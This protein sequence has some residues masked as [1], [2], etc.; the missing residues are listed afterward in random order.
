MI[1]RLAAATALA[2]VSVPAISAPAEGPSRLLQGSDLFS[3]EVATDPQIRPDG[4]MIAYVRRSNDVMTDR[5]RATIWLVDAKTGAQTPLVAGTG[6]HSQ[7]RWSPDGKR[8]AYVSTAEGG[9]A[10]L[11]VRWMDTGA[12]ARVATLPDGPSAISWSPDGTRIAFIMSV[13]DE[14][15]KLGTPPA[16]PEGAKWAPPLEVISSIVYRADGAG[17]LKPGYDHVFVVPADGGA[18]RQLTFGA[19][20]HDGPLSWTPDGRTILLS[21]DRSK[22]WQREPNNPE[23]YALDVATAKLTALTDRLGPDA[24]PVVSPDGKRI[25]Y[26]GYD[27]KYRG[28]ENALLYV[29]DRDGGNARAI[30]TALDRSIDDAEWA[31]DGRSLY[32]QYDDHGS[33]RV[34]RVTLDGKLTTVAT[35]MTSS[36]I[37]RPYSGGSFSVARNGAVA[38]TS[39]DPQRPADVSIASGGKSRRLTRLNE[40]LLGAKALGQ[41]RQIPVKAADGRAID[42][43]LVTP[44]DFD[45]AKKYPM[46]LEI[47][48]GPFAAYG[49]AFASDNQLYA[50]AGY[51]VLYVNPRGSTSYGAE[52]ANLIHHAYPGDDYGDLMAAVDAAIAT[53]SI[54][55]DNLFVTGGSGGGVLT[56]WI[57]GKTDRFKAAA[58]QKPVIDWASF[59]LTADMTPFFAKYWFGKFPWEDPQAYWN[60]SPLSLVGNVKTPTLVVVGSEDYRTPVSEA[61]QYYSALQLRGIPTALVKVPEASHGGIAARPSQSASKASAILAWFDKY[62]AKPQ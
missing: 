36:Q 49:P 24:R 18:P 19:F 31:A 11:F 22:N 23:I 29:M 53:G 5:A 13:P 62:R 47:H 52:F 2:L 7:P 55:A 44:P 12:T 57:V 26:L 34:A 54:D 25:A 46:I 42:A 38:F 32:V 16:K 37:D 50:A 45:P 41:V 8:I 9:A 6:S 48:G 28:Y 39:G 3:L 17:Y 43:W 20:N 40:E 59:V 61:E 1:L 15:M 35:G 14:G 51:A 27:D 58:T 60:R 56:A 10:Q 21:A 4:A 30:T 33:T